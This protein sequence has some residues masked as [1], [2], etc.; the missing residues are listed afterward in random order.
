M[1]F[2]LSAAGNEPKDQVARASGLLMASCFRHCLHSCFPE[3]CPIKR[4]IRVSS[5]EVKEF[6]PIRR[7]RNLRAL[8]AESSYIPPLASSGIPARDLER[9]S[10]AL[11]LGMLPH[12]PATSRNPP[13]ARPRAGKTSIPPAA[14]LIFWWRSSRKAACRR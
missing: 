10:V 9:P 14:T 3:C 11:E 8:R 6:L 4:N 5:R 1:P 12:P 7:H 2:P 13:S